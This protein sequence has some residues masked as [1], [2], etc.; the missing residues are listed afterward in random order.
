MKIR[1]TSALAWPDACCEAHD[2]GELRKSV[3][4]HLMVRLVKFLDLIAFVGADR[5]TRPARALQA[6]RTNWKELRAALTEADRVLVSATHLWLRKMPGRLHP[7][8]LCRFYPRVA[9]RLA[10]CWDEPVTC[11]RLLA[12]LIADRRGGRAGFPPRIQA[13]LHV[14]TQLRERQ[15]DGSWQIRL[16]DLRGPRPHA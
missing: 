7:R 14:L 10:M 6:T 2:S 13:E 12:E 11:K 15:S 16:R 3:D 4:R 1:R 8:H 9:N 5:A